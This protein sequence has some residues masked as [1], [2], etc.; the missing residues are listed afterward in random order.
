MLTV[1]KFGGSSLDGAERLRRAAALAA[2]GAHSGGIV[3][4][5]SARG[6]TTNELIAQTECISAAPPARELDAFLSCGEISSASLMAMQLS[7]MGYDCISLSGAQA[8]IKT[9]DIHGSARITGI[10][11]RRITHELSL[12]KIVIIAGFQGENTVGDI[13]TI[14]R[15]GSDT[16]AVELAAALNADKCIIYSDV[17]GV[18][19]ADPRLVTGA[20]RLDCID[21]GDML[22]LAL[23][24]SQ[25]LHS[26][27]VEA[28]MRTGVEPL[29]LSS[30]SDGG[31]T[32]LKRM[33]HR[34]D[35]CGITRDKAAGTIS[36]VGKN[37]GIEVLA[38]AVSVLAHND[39]IVSA[40]DVSAGVCRIST[41]PDKL[42]P[43][44]ELTH[45]RFFG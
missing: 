27:S 18:Y 44:L 22:Q 3:A 31:G 7:A 9:D 5:V 43:A 14:G 42:L 28:A 37:A 38:E 29:L 12:G 16:T 33:E 39:I 36:I 26:R 1:K 15:G 30:F 24:G 4:V 17:D 19:T 23:G 6:N 10:D 45:R 21:Y 20:V 11:T 25:V 2:E 40:T 13:T 34:P 8:G 35:I 32:V 41:A